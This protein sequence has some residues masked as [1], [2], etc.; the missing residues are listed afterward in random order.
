MSLA[1]LSLSGNQMTFVIEDALY[2]TVQTKFSYLGGILGCLGLSI[3]VVVVGSGLT[4]ELLWNKNEQQDKMIEAF[5]QKLE[6]QQEHI[7]LLVKELEDQKLKTQTWYN[8]QMYT[9]K[10]LEKN[11]RLHSKLLAQQSNDIRSCF[12]CLNTHTTIADNHT[13]TLTNVVRHQYAQTNAINKLHKD[14]EVVGDAFDQIDEIR[15]EFDKFIEQT[16][17]SFIEIEVKLEDAI[18]HFQSSKDDA[19]ERMDSLEEELL[20]KVL[21]ISVEFEEMVECVRDEMKFM[22]DRVEEV[23]REVAVLEK[24]Q[25]KMEDD[26]ATLYDDFLGVSGQV[27]E[28]SEDFKISPVVIC[29]SP[30]KYVPRNIEELRLDECGTNPTLF[31]NLV[32]LKHVKKIHLNSQGIQLNDFMGTHPLIPINPTFNPNN[33]PAT[34]LVSMYKDTRSFSGPHYDLLRKF[35]NHFLSCGTQICFNGIP[36]NFE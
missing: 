36:I 28:L 14:L 19:L 34:L 12:D 27:S 16:D 10:E 18:D 13:E 15:E 4:V 33:N 24:G 31:G 2:T 35:I 5:Q 23:D 8:I 1:N 26:F 22:S 6:K 21:D 3:F 29:N 32:T 7:D 30:F 25:V 20:D 17:Q 9:D 11:L